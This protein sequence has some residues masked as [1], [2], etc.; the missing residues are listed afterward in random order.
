[1]LVLLR[2]LYR[3]IIQI[4]L[5][6][7]Q[8]RSHS[9]LHYRYLIVLAIA[10][11]IAILIL[12]TASFAQEP[13]PTPAGDVIEI[14]GTVSQITG[15]TLVVAGL[16]VDA[17]NISLDAAITVGTTVTVTGQVSNNVIIAQSIVLVDLST[18]TATLPA[19]PDATPQITPTPTND[20][21][22][23][24]VIEGPVINI[25]NNIITIFDFDVEVAPQHPIL[26][27]IDI[28]DNLH[29][30]GTYGTGGVIVAT[31]V[32]NITNTTIVNNT[33]PTA[34]VRLD[35]PIEAI[36]GTTLVVN[37]IPA[38]L[39]P[40]DPILQ[41]ARVGDFVSLQ[42]NFENNGTTI[43]LV[44]VNITIINNVVINENPYCWYHQDGMGMGHWHCDGMG[45]GMG[46]GMEAD[47]GMGMGMGMGMGQ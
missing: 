35:G 26:T 23:I 13:T 34:A 21:D 30:E 47:P 19:T 9:Q 41:T 4:P 40:N 7:S 14:T 8:M 17:S 37:G 6:V 29:V 28:G 20:P 12:P 32:S 22:T 25:V 3:Q 43:I 42:G 36:N 38:Q 45:M 15:T 46:M 39:A 27:I 2:R 11:L 31:F 33:A 18:P 24:I 1:M 44:V 5:G 16:T 10:T